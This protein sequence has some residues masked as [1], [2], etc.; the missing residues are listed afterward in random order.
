M[1]TGR[2]VGIT[3]TMSEKRTIGSIRRQ[4]ESSR[5]DLERL[6]V[7]EA[8]YESQ[9]PLMEA[10]WDLEGKLASAEATQ[11]TRRALLTGVTIF[12]AAVSAVVSAVAAWETHRQ[13]VLAGQQLQLTVTQLQAQTGPEVDV[14]LDR[15]TGELVIENSGAV[16]VIEGSVAAEVHT[17]VNGLRRSNGS[18]P[19]ECRWSRLGPAEAKRCSLQEAAAV[20][21]QD[22]Q[23]VEKALAKSAKVEV[24]DPVVVARVQYRREADRRLFSKTLALVAMCCGANG[25]P[26]LFPGLGVPKEVDDAIGDIALGSLAKPRRLGR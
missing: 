17:F 2:D 7:R 9:K 11:E 13:A 23:M 19:L 22:A 21:M 15:K 18:T 6:R 26:T 12:I 1:G 20:A 3:K 25:K 10:V 16:P 8:S 14:R 4:L 24:L 5:Q